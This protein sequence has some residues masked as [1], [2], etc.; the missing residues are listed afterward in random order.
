MDII[1]EIKEIPGIRDLSLTTNGSLLST[2]ADLLKNAGLDRLN[3]SIWSL[4]PVTYQKITGHDGLAN[5]LTSLDLVKNLDFKQVKLNY[6]LLR[7]YN[8]TEFWDILD[9][10]HRYNFIL[11]L[12]ELH[13]FESI[14]RDIVFEE[15]YI[16][17]GE[18][19]GLFLPFVKSNHARLQMQ[20]R[21]V[22]ELDF[23]AKI[24]AVRYGCKYLCPLQQNPLNFRWKN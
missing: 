6:T 22:Y 18:I 11:Q 12:I 10:A 7:H 3:I 13:K 17:I 8:I 1:R 24:E 21:K 19:E 4:D 20:N 23:G 5:L 16:G 2:K 9:L 14:N 15:E